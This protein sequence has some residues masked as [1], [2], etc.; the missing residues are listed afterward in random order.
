MKCGLIGSGHVAHAFG[1]HFATAET[2]V[3]QWSR[4]GVDVVPGVDVEADW[5]GWDVAF[6]AVADGALGEVA[7]RVP[8]GTWR[9][10][11]SG[12]QP[13]SSVVPAGERGAVMWPVCSIR[14]EHP[15]VWDGLH[16]AV[17]ATDEGVFT[18]ADQI[19]RRL[20]GTVHRMSSDQRLEAHAAAVFAANFTNLMLAEAADLGAATGLPWAALHRLAAGVFDRSADPQAVGH[21]TG[22]AARGDG[23]TLDAHARVLAQH[24]ELQQLYM[25]LSARIQQRAHPRKP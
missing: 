7:R 15:P 22:P 6:L 18:W 19:L 5:A 13:L 23:A 17:E 9:V 11:F 1:R 21:L 25:Q 8:A 10:H 3:G 14:K 16:W 2:W 20:G 4:A 24:P 12:A